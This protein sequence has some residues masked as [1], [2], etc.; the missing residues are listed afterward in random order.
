MVYRTGR[1]LDSVGVL[2]IAGLAAGLALGVVAY[3][4]RLE[5]S[6][7]AILARNAIPHRCLDQSCKLCNVELQWLLHNPGR[8]L[9]DVVQAAEAGVIVGVSPTQEYLEDED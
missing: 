9:G 7:D 2:G 5:D 3:S 6:P 1:T 4:G 8:S